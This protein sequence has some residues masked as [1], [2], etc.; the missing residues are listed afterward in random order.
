MAKEF[1]SISWAVSVARRFMREAA[2]T[3][4]R[5]LTSEN[6]R[7]LR[8]LATAL[9]DK[10]YIIMTEADMLKHYWRFFPIRYPIKD[11]NPKIWTI[12]RDTCS[13]RDGRYSL[14][15]ICVR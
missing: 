6:D 8:D 7:A 14:A 2:A 11:N 1:G 10:G 5:Q 12:Q 4:D 3:K 15:I 9:S 13:D